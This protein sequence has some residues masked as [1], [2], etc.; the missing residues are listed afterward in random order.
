[1][2]TTSPGGE[3]MKTDYRNIRHGM[4]INKEDW[5]Q[6]KTFGALEVYELKENKMIHVMLEDD[7]VFGC[8]H[9]IE[10]CEFYG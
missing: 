7:K 5:N 6:I 3:R 1:M 4:P 8:A 10:T 9:N 2:E